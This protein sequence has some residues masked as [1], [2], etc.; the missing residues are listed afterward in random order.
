MFLLKHDIFVVVGMLRNTL[1]SV[2][3]ILRKFS[4]MIYLKVWSGTVIQG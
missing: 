1:H 4:M 2:C 3:V